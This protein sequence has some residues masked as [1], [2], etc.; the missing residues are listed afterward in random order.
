[1]DRCLVFSFYIM[2]CLGSVTS[3]VG[4]LLI[5]LILKES[6]STKLGEET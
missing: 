2:I 1:M 5:R 3:L 6:F 4:F